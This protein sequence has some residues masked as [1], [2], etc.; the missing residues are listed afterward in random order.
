MIDLTYNEMVRS[1]DHSAFARTPGYQ[2]LR[3][4]LDL[5]AWELREYESTASLREVMDALWDMV[6]T[7][8]IADSCPRCMDHAHPHRLVRDDDDGLKA[9]YLHRCKDGRDHEWTCN[10]GMGIYGVEWSK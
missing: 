10:W 9:Y 1:Y 8:P 7:G 4:T 5:L 6:A 2:D 3:K